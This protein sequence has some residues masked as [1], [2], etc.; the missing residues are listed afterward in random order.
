MRRILWYIIVAA[1]L[2]AAAG[3]AFYLR[4]LYLP[5]P[6]E[7]EVYRQVVLSFD[8]SGPDP[9][10]DWEEKSLARKRTEYSVDEIDGRMALKAV[11][12]G[13]CS[14]MYFR[15]R[16][17]FRE[18]PYVK[19]DWSV[20]RF[21]ERE[22][23]ET[24]ESRDEFDFAA[25]F[26][27]LFFSRFIMNTRAIQYVWAE[28]LPEGTT[29]VNPYAGN[30]RVK[31]LRSGGAG[32]WHSEERDIAA[33]HLELFGTELDRDIVAIAFMSDSDNTES[34]TEA[35]VTNIEMGYL[36]FPEEPETENG[37]E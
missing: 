2:L 18:R 14:A 26:Y 37:T 30:L 31:V 5:E 13:S 21:P 7:V 20:A 23:E 15:E 8:F 32:E 34:S 6:V 11:S 17:S 29:G 24:L 19:W 3:A 33:D 10:A 12:E 1:G 36:F 22:G 28:S 35:Y 27:V 16:L 9:L 4:Q 25:H